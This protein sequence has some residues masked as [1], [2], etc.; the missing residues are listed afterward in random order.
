MPDNL[1]ELTLAE[2]SVLVASIYY[3]VDSLLLERQAIDKSKTQAL[4]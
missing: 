3:G 2:Y 4:D 1:S